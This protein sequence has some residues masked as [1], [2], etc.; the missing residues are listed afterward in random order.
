[1]KPT[2]EEVIAWG[3]SL[4]LTEPLRSYG[5]NQNQLGFFYDKF[6]AQRSAV[7]REAMERLPKNRKLYE[8]V[9]KREVGRGGSAMMDLGKDQKGTLVFVQDNG[10]NQ[11]ADEA[12]AALQ[13]M[14]NTT[15]EKE[16]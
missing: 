16:V 10:Y 15:M 2:D 14:L 4:G 13:A 7:I 11:A 9:T 12:R 5:L 8:P 1:M 6:Q 3:R